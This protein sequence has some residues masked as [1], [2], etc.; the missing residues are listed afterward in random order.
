MTS[1][2]I[3]VTAPVLIVLAWLRFGYSPFVWIIWAG[4]HG[5]ALRLQLLAS[6]KVAWTHFRAEYP[7]RVRSVREEFVGL[8]RPLTVR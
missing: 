3:F 8:G 5:E 2:L 6:L 1:F 7:V 4:I